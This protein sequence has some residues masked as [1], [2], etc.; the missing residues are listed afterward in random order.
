MKNL[1]RDL[2]E[3]VWECD[4][5]LRHTFASEN[6]ARIMGRRPEELIGLP[7]YAFIAP[8]ERAALEKGISRLIE[9]NSP[10]GEFEMTYMTAT[11]GR[12]ALAIRAAA[13]Y[14][15]DG[16]LEKIIGS[17]MDMT[18]RNVMTRL[19]R[20]NVHRF[21]DLFEN[22]ATC[23]VILMPIEDGGD[24]VINDLNPAARRVERIE[25]TMFHGRRVIDIFPDFK[26]DGIIEVLRR[27]HRTGLSESYPVYRHRDGRIDRWREH[28][29]FQLET[30]EIVVAYHDRTE[31]MKARENAIGHEQRHRQLF[32]EMQAGFALHEMI[33]DAKGRMIDYRFLDVNPAFETMTGR[34]KEAIVGKTAREAFPGIE[35][36]WFERYGR[37]ALQGEKLHFESRTGVLDR[38]FDV[39]AFSPA[40]RLFATIILDVT[41]RRRVEESLISTAKFA[42][43]G[44]IT[45]GMAHELNQPLNAIKSFC[46][47]V[48]LN[49][50][51]GIAMTT[52]EIVTSLMYADDQVN[53]MAEIIQTMK[54]F[55]TNSV[56]SDRAVV[57]LNDII[58][59]AL[60]AQH[61]RMIGERGGTL[62]VERASSP[63]PVL[64]N[65]RRIQQ[66][67]VNIVLNAFDEVEGRTTV[68]PRIAI[69][70]R[71]SEETKEAI[72]EVED[73]GGGVPPGIKEHIFEPF[74]TTKDP[75][76]GMGLGLAICQD[77]VVKHNGLIECHDAPGGGTI[78]RV[79][80]PLVEEAEGGRRGT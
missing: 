2:D 23:V 68:A 39:V 55:A 58:S 35:E 17:G 60:F 5:N 65:P 8:E 78:F 75:D 72:I 70:V 18:D 54:S 6:I 49:L 21:R 32:T 30:G 11:G 76:K 59:T 44:R 61:R 73:N 69:R 25:L 37:V 36:F 14:H 33:T 16:R 24:F 40:P 74:V 62:T 31:E 22:I 79:R 67:M 19:L 20:Y 41:E 10:R 27:V 71:R 47:E 12:L 43:F 64:V 29:V 77:I 57:N 46:Q 3:F 42:A 15:P 53:R 38:W 4:G 34:A 26:K 50:R 66:V 51:D 48:I 7:I 63:C 13:S 1:L 56:E 45:A 9:K 80:L 52:E 28:H